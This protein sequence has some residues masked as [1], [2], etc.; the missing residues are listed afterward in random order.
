M[1]LSGSSSYIYHAEP[2]FGKHHALVFIFFL[3]T[4]LDD[5]HYHQALGDVPFARC[6][7]TYE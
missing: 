5:Q 7:L 3:N 1:S 6:L 4:A 2:L